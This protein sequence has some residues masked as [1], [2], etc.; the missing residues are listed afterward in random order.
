MRCPKPKVRGSINQ[1]LPTGPLGTGDS[2]MGRV[3]KP[4]EPWRCRG[5]S[6]SILNP[7]P[8]GCKPW[9]VCTFY[10]PGSVHFLY[11]GECTLSIYC[12]SVHFLYPRE[13]AFSISRGVYTFYIPL[14]V[15]FLY[16]GVCTLYISRGVYTFYI[17]G[18]VHFLY[19]GE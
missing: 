5:Y 11:P 2:G 18:C 16:L 3:V 7:E 9:R 4:E 12:E 10:I 15:H 8:R 1:L 14:S 13:C 19:P 17:L 6:G